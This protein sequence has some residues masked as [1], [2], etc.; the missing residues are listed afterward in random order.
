MRSFRELI[1][2]LAVSGTALLLGSRSGNALENRAV[3]SDN[4]RKIYQVASAYSNDNDGMIVPIYNLRGVKKQ[5]FWPELLL[6]YV[7]DF[8]IYYCPDDSSGKKNLKKHDLLPMKFSISNVSYGLNYF[9]S[10]TKKGPNAE[11]PY[12]IRRVADPGY[13]IYFGDARFVHLRPTKW[14]W[15]GDYNP[16]HSGGS[17]FVMADGHVEYFKGKTLGV[18]H[19]FN[20][21]K[22]DIKRWKNWKKSI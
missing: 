16:V 18:Y 12:N 1:L 5:T 3:C 17:N 6:D 14:C 15:E 8:S 2:V 13:V 7:N 4:L 21:W 20:G 10:K 9:I 11:N 19:E 22:Q